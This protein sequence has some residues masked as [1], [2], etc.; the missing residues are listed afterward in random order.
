MP[1]DQQSKEGGAILVGE[2]FLNYHEVPGLLLHNR[3]MEE[4]A[5]NSGDSLRCL[6]LLPF[7]TVTVNEKL[8]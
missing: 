8:S 4:Y 3:S 2:V 7:L 5:W 6:L 1:V